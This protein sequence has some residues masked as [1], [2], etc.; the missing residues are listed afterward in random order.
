MPYTPEWKIC[1]ICEICVRE[2]MAKKSRK[3]LEVSEIFLIFAAD[4][5]FKN[6]F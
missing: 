6:I 2:S 1:V 3:D 4:K 5:L